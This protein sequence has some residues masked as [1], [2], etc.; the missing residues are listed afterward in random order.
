MGHLL[1][2]SLFDCGAI[3]H[4]WT[5]NVPCV[6]VLQ[7]SYADVKNGGVAHHG[8]KHCMPRHQVPVCSIHDS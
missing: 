8:A 6:A 3:R 5:T 4:L 7:S 2:D 1:S